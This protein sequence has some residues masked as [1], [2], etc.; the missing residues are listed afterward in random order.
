MIVILLQIPEHGYPVKGIKNHRYGMFRCIP[1]P[2]FPIQHL[3]PAG[4][5]PPPSSLPQKLSP[6]TQIDMPIIIFLFIT[7]PFF[8]HREQQVTHSFPFYSFHRMQ[9]TMRDFFLSDPQ[10]F[11]NAQI[12]RINV[13]IP[14][15]FSIRFQYTEWSWCQEI[16]LPCLFIKPL[17]LP[18]LYRQF[19]FL[20]CFQNPVIRIR[21]CQHISLHLFTAYALQKSILFFRL[22]SFCQR[23]G[24]QPF[25]HRH[26]RLNDFS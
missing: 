10:H 19:S 25:R 2:D 24:M 4:V 5:Y 16:C 11:Q 1:F 12:F 8:I 17:I 15:R 20:H 6:H 23:M 22:N 21:P 18:H 3:N 14:Y 26:D 9:N 7:I 13:Q